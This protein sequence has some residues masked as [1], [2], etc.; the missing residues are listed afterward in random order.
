M[1]VYF[2]APIIHEPDYLLAEGINLWRDITSTLIYTSAGGSYSI[3]TISAIANGTDSVDIV[4]QI[5]GSYEVL[6]TAVPIS[7]IHI[8]D[9]LI[10]S[11]VSVAVV[12]L[13]E[14]FTSSSRPSNSLLA[15]LATGGLYVINLKAG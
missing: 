14:L 11:D 1:P 2:S 7:H 12:Q 9:N 6:Y 13:N 8:N 10:S 4:E 15:G 5:N 3:D